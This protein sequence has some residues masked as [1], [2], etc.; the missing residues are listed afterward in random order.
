MYQ[1][2]CVDSQCTDISGEELLHLRDSANILVLLNLAMIGT[3]LMNIYSHVNCLLTSS[4]LCTLVS[5]KH[6]SSGI[7]YHWP[8]AQ[9]LNIMVLVAI[10]YGKIY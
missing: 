8:N 9:N 10:I 3:I 6:L 2:I 5:I 4:P 7:V 1:L